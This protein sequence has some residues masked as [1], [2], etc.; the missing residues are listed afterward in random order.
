MQAG[1]GRSNR[2]GPRREVL[3]AF[4]AAA[5]ALERARGEEQL[6]SIQG[7][8]AQKPGAKPTLVLPDGSV[9]TP[10]GDPSTEGVLNDARLNGYDLELL[11]TL[12]GPGQFAV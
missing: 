10:S 9:V 4:L 8:L 12:T 1:P 3:T 7:K 5:A 11:G 6:T 2:G